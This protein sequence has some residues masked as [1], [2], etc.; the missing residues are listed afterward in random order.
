MITL[1]ENRKLW[2]LISDIVK[3]TA[4]FEQSGSGSDAKRADSAVIALKDFMDTITI[5]QEPT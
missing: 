1:E 5:V 2:S 4:N 3:T